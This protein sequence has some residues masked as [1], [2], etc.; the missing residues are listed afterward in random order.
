MFGQFLTDSADAISKDL[1]EAGLVDGKNMVVGK[2]DTYFMFSLSLSLSP[3]PLSLT[4]SLFHSV[5]AN[6]QKLV[7]NPST[8]KVVFHVVSMTCINF[9]LYNDNNGP[10]VD[11]IVH[12][13]NFYSSV[14]L[15]VVRYCRPHLLL[16]TSGMKRT[17]L[18]TH[19]YQEVLQHR[20]SLIVALAQ[21]LFYSNI[22]V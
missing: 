2:S 16:K 5:A 9:M 8:K 20:L 3:P 18:A 22:I 21:N 6:I 17:S 13:I 11:R 1:V 10:A 19:N 14:L 12:I 4:C 15:Y 7:E